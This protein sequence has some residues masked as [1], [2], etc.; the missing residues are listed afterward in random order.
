MLLMATGTPLYVTVTLFE[1]FGDPA[2]SLKLTGVGLVAKPVVLPLPIVRV[3]VKLNGPDAVF[4][5]TVPV[6]LPPE[7]TA[8]FALTN[9]LPKVPPTDACSQLCPEFVVTDT[10]LTCTAMPLLVMLTGTD[11]NELDGR[12]NETGLGLAPR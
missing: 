12:L 10:L 7:N 5:V 8:A 4:T 9:T 11:E 2:A 3:A 6:S 1:S